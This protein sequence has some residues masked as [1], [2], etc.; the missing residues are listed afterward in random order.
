MRL[1]KA[2]YNRS[3]LNHSLHLDTIAIFLKDSMLCH[4]NRCH[5]S[6]IKNVCCIESLN[7]FLERSCSLEV[8][9]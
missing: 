1:Y 5:E 7:S 8:V 2:N 6:Y 4:I 3:R 9:E